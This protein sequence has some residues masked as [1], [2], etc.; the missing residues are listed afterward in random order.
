MQIKYVQGNV[1]VFEVDNTTYY[2]KRGNGYPEIFNTHL[3]PQV[4][5]NVDNWFQ[6]KTAQKYSYKNVCDMADAFAAGMAHSYNSQ[7]LANIIGTTITMMRD[8]L[9]NDGIIHDYH[10]HYW[11]E[12]M[13]PE[14]LG[15]YIQVLRDKFV[16][17]RAEH[18][19]AKLY[20]I[21]CKLWKMSKRSRPADS[22][23][24]ERM[25]TRLHRT[26]EDPKQPD[27]VD[28]DS[29]IFHKICK[30]LLSKYAAIKDVD[31]SVIEKVQAL[32]G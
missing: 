4:I 26:P 14:K 30:D 27:T 24:F 3:T 9:F 13:R 28:I 2:M 20:D 12:M 1:V 11:V 22:G 6:A 17:V 16:A 23:V 25:I 18:G 29:A 5:Y 10:K 31:K 19:D 7:D 8:A 21:L 32:N 15:A